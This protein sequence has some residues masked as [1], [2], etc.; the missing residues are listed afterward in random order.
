M[1]SMFSITK[2]TGIPPEKVVASG[3][4]DQPSA[5]GYVAAVTTGSPDERAVK[6]RDHLRLVRD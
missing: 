6:K 2:I 1:G 3:G 5:N 4:H